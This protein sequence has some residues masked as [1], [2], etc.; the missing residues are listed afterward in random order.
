VTA[1]AH[2]WIRTPARGFV[3]YDEEK[4]KGLFY[5]KRSEKLAPCD[6]SQVITRTRR[7]K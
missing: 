4:N 2:R 7:D 6:L 1:G 3:V 5:R